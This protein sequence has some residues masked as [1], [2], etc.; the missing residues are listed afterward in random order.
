MYIKL[1]LPTDRPIEL[2]LLGFKQL[3]IQAVRIL[4]KDVPNGWA[5]LSHFAVWPKSL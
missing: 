5:E 2:L 1:E 3:D 4:D